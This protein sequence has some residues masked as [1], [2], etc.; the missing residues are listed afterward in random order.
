MAVV[1]RR[2][3]NG[4]GVLKVCLVQSKHYAYRL[5]FARAIAPEWVLESLKDLRDNI[6]IGFKE[7]LQSSEDV[8]PESVAEEEKQ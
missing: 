2:I 5:H 6:Q 1:V 8:G 7:E 3:M 4:T